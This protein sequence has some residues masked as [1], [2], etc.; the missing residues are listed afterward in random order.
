MTSRGK[1]SV[2]FTWVDN[3][4]QRYS[5]KSMIYYGTDYISATRCL[6]NIRR[7][8]IERRI[9]RISTGILGI[10]Y[11]IAN[12][13]NKCHTSAV[14][15]LLV[16]VLNDSYFYVPLTSD[17]NGSFSFTSHRFLKQNAVFVEHFD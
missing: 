4:R 7:L 5:M 12:Q 2:R 9:P 8:I 14:C 16:Y 10:L 11:S 13:F 17:V 1:L 3:A 6:L 15:R